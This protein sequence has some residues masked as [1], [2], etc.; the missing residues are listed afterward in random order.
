MENKKSLTWDEYF[1][2]TCKQ[3]ST[4]SPCLSRHIGAILVSDH[5]IISTGYNGPAR[6]IPH[7]GKDR[8]TKDELLSSIISNDPDY[9]KIY[10]IKDIFNICPRHILGYQSGEHMELCPA[11]HAEENC[12]SN[13]ARNGTS[14]LNSILYLSGPIPCKNCYST[15]INAGIVEIVCED[16]N[17]YDQYTKFISTN[18]NIKL[19]KFNL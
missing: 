18:S 17:Y 11:Q 14:T 3:I 1:Y 19:R 12:V 16:I 9:G 6:G 2:L 10:G 13:A 4:K 5:S 8:Y 7:C 15:L